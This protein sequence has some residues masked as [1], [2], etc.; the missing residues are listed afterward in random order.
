MKNILATFL[1][2]T[3]MFS[4]KAQD[5]QFSNEALQA[6]FQTIENETVNFKEILENYKGKTV[7]IDVWASWCGD[8]IKGMPK[9]KE[10][11]AQHTDVTFVFL[12]VDKNFDSWKKGIERFNVQGE[13]YFIP[14]GMKG[15]FGKAINLSWIPRYILIDKSGKVAYYNATEATDAKLLETL[16]KIK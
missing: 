10:L 8:C 9:V 6:N 12:S 5:S 16:N 1:L 13:H 7:L 14:D 4:C 11:Q 15:N 2:G 3:L